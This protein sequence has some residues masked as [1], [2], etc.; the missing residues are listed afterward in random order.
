MNRIKTAVLGLGRIGWQY[1]IP[2]M[3]GHGG[4]DFVAAV[5]PL[6][7]RRA[8]AEKQYQVRTYESTAEMYD[9]EKPGLVIIASPSHLHCAQAVEAMR[10]GADVFV[11]KPMACTLAQGDEMI[12]TMRTTGRKMMSFQPMRVDQPVQAMKSILSG[13]KLGTLYMVKHLGMYYAR[14]NDWQALRQYGGGSLNNGGSHMIDCMLHLT[15]SAVSSVACQMQR[16]ASL[17]DAEDVVKILLK[18]ESGVVVD[19]DMNC[20]SATDD[21]P[22]WIL[23]GSHGSAVHHAGEEGPG[24]FELKYFNENEMPQ[25]AM[26]PGM[27]ALDRKYMKEQQIPWKTETVRLDAFTA[28]N[29]YDLCYE[30]FALGKPSAV[31]VEQTREVLHIIDKCRKFDGNFL[32][33]EG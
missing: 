10:R 15:G 1:H 21:L 33:P 26:N 6:Q 31:P 7:E 22:Q 17:G 11:D 32:L 12:E 13:G 16:I 4:F 3:V 18:M 30:Y 2:T 19:I 5:D 28:L 27:A 8:E 24:T 23:L 29:F 25:R 14:R 9:C 20:A